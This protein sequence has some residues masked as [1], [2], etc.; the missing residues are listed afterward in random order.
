MNYQHQ[1]AYTIHQ[2]PAM[3]AELQNAF[4]NRVFGWMTM[5][6]AITGGISYY[7]GNY[8]GEFIVN[9]S[10]IFI[11]L[12]IIEF[13][14]V[15]GLSA[16]ISK[17]SPM[18]AF[19]GFVLFAAL[20]G[21]TLSSIFLVYTAN[22]IASTFFTASLTFGAMGLYGWVTKRDLT[23]VGSLCFMFLIGI[24]IASLINI[25]VQ[26]YMFNLIISG[27][28]VL[29]FVG[30]TAYDTQKIKQLSIAIS[31]GNISEIDGQK[32]AV[33]GALEL[34]LDFINLFLYLL[35][36]MGKRK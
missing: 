13:L 36:F 11:F 26:S 14:L 27:I 12:L 25:F 1:Q 8:H 5:G 29:I 6:L 28:G 7:L 30:L 3:V 9:N 2:D 15:L 16:A 21:V 19:L 35:R 24:I 22:S 33:L 17:I 23:S 18:V 32:F 10:G 31:E 4:V 34:Y 20:N